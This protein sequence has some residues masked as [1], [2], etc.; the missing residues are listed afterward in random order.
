MSLGAIREVRSRI[1]R[2]FSSGICNL[3]FTIVSRE[4][5]QTTLGHKRNPMSA[6]REEMRVI[7]LEDPVPM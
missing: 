3:L 1:R 7:S 4:R 6:L 5:I 2:K